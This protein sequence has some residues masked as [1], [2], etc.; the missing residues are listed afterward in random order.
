MQ[1]FPWPHRDE[2]DALGFYIREDL[3]DGHISLRGMDAVSLHL[4]GPV[5]HMGVHHHNVLHLLNRRVLV[6][7]TFRAD[8]AALLG[9]IRADHQYRAAELRHHL[10]ALKAATPPRTAYIKDPYGPQE[11]DLGPLTLTPRRVP[12]P[13]V[14]VWLFGES[15][16]SIGHASVPFTDATWPD[17]VRGII[18]TVA[19][20]LRGLIEAQDHA[21]KLATD[22]IFRWSL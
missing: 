10:A 20:H 11:F 7:S 18:I 2:H 5:P 1:D 6:P 14:R 22:L 17:V 19:E 8:V 13:A 4:T 16:P 3:T 21:A 12:T 9:T 15:L